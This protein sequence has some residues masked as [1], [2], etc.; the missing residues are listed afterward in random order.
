MVDE[1]C[2][3]GRSVYHLGIAQKICWDGGIGRHTGLQ[4]EPCQGNL[5][6]GCGDIGERFADKIRSANTEGTFEKMNAVETRY[7]YT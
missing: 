7:P 4:L 5:A 6:S 3:S 2:K 1:R